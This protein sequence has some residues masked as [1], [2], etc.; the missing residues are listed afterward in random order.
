MRVSETMTSPGNRAATE[1]RSNLTS[2]S[3]AMA[4]GTLVERVEPGPVGVP[5]EVDRQRP[6]RGFRP[7]CHAREDQ[8]VVMRLPTA[9]QRGGKRDA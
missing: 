1:A 2:D 3:V 5:A 8:A 4:P 6:G 7:D 9:A